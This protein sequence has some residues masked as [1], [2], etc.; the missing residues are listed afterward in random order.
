MRG[1]AALRVTA[2]RLFANTELRPVAMLGKFDG[3]S[4]LQLLQAVIF[5]GA[6]SGLRVRNTINQSKRGGR[7]EIRFVRLA[8]PVI[9]MGP[10][11]LKHSRHQQQVVQKK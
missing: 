3:K 1:G 9:Y 7:S 6:T 2:V 8:F 11:S 5:S 4:L 10:C